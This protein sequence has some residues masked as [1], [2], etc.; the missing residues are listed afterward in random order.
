MDPRTVTDSGSEPVWMSPQDWQAMSGAGS[1]PESDYGMR[2]G[3]DQNVRVSYAPFTGAG[4]EGSGRLYAFEPSSARYALLADVTTQ[5]EVDAAWDWLVAR[6]GGDGLI[7]FTEWTA[8]L[9]QESTP[10]VPATADAA[11]VEPIVIRV[12]ATVPTESD[13]ARQ[14]RTVRW[15]EAQDLDAAV[16]EIAGLRSRVEAAG[17]TLKVVALSQAGRTFRLAGQEPQSSAPPTIQG[18]APTDIAMGM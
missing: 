13:L 17:G 15:L 2:W 1:G 8:L 4:W 16:D 3:I 14:E 6:H 7:D 5:S 11:T 18:A 9:E 10:V 12:Q